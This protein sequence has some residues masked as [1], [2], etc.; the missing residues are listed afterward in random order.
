MNLIL[1]ILLSVALV[2]I[3]FTGLALQILVK[4]NGKFPN[5]HVGG[6]PHLM[7]QGISCAKTQDKIEQAKIRQKIDFNKIRFVGIDKK[8]DF[9]R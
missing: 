5:T 7:R 3:A 4:R 6:N 1:I 8:D 9:N 2:A